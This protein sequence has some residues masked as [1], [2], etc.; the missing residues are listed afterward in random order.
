MKNSVLFPLRSRVENE[1]RKH[2]RGSK[3]SEKLNA[4]GREARDSQLVASQRRAENR[5]A[6]KHQIP[7]TSS[8]HDSTAFFA[9][10][11]DV[12]VSQ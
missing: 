8:F 2:T 4:R 5:P 11:R 10:V 12:Q 3:H 9:G 6:V 7:S 1:W